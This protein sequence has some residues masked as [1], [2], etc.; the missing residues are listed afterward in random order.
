MKLEMTDGSETSAHKV[1]TAGNHPKE[2]I[3]HEASLSII[4]S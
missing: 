3:K 1:Q 2:R 4:A